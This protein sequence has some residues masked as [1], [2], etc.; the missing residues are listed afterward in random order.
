MAT[1]A[2]CNIYFSAIINRPPYLV[3]WVVSARAIYLLHHMC[4]IHA[5][6]FVRLF[7]RASKW[8]SQNNWSALRICIQI[9]TFG[10]IYIN[11]E[12]NKVVVLLWFELKFPYEQWKK[13]ARTSRSI[14]L[15]MHQWQESSSILS[16]GHLHSA[17]FIRLEYALHRYGL[18]V[19]VCDCIC[20]IRSENK[21]M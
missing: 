1:G 20:M 11:I 6:S 19:C 13:K 18:G 12:R 16:L 17:H 21:F 14:S 10:L 3:V 4:A 9:E 15:Y 5:I 8:R 2:F 7:F